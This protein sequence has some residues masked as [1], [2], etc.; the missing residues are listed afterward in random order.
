LKSKGI[1][2]SS[3]TR[4]AMLKHYRTVL[5]DAVSKNQGLLISNPNSPF[6]P[7]EHTLNTYYALPNFNRQNAK[8]LFG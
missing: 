8:H 7:D 3:G 6:R 2:Y 5:D 1:D 4:S